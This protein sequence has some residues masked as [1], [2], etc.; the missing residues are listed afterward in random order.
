MKEIKH[1][2]DITI[3]TQRAI[4]YIIIFVF[5]IIIFAGC[6]SYYYAELYTIHCSEKDFVL[7]VDSLKSVHPEYK[8]TV[9]APDGSLVDS[10]SP[11]A[12]FS[13]MG[14]TTLLHY[15]FYFYIPSENKLFQCHIIPYDSLSSNEEFTLRFS[16]VCDTN[17]S[18]NYEL[19]SGKSTREKDARYKH[20]FEKLILDKLNVKWD[21]EK[22]LW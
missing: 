11:R 19:N 5:S 13:S 2:N 4:R 12:P 8:W 1:T 10:D 17:H 3:L 18:D 7:K 22:L 21:R 14:D 20:L 15:D 16:H 6:G 9:H